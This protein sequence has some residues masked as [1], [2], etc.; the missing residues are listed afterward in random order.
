MEYKE[1]VV[2]LDGYLK[3]IT[4]IGASVGYVTYNA[5]SLKLSGNDF[6][7]SYMNF[8]NNND[9][10]DILDIEFPALKL[11]QCK[12]DVDWAEIVTSNFNRIFGE[13]KSD[14]VHNALTQT[15]DMLYMIVSESFSRKVFLCDA[16]MGDTSGGYLF[17]Q[18]KNEEYLVLS[19][20]QKQ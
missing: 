20:L 14:S 13:R 10:A 4:T 8:I 18:G 15:L 19:F 16:E 12:A 1:N 2:W 11:S 6:A 3:G 17:F 7:Q 9:D 5:L